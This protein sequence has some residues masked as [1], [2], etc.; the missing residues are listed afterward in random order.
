MKGM[1]RTISILVVDDKEDS[2]TELVSALQDAGYS[3]TAADGGATALSIL[4]A[5]RFDLLL[6]D[7]RVADITAPEIVQIVRLIHTPSEL[8]VIVLNDEA[9]DGDAHPAQQAVADECITRPTDSSLL[10]QRIRAL[11]PEKHTQEAT[12]CEDLADENLEALRQINVGLQAELEQRKRVEGVLRKEI[13]LRRHIERGLRADERRF[14]LL[15]DKTPTMFFTVDLKGEIISANQFGARNLGY[16]PDELIGMPISRLFET[17]HRNSAAQQLILCLQNPDR[18][19]RR[20]SCMVRKDGSTLWVRETSRAAEGQGDDAPR[21]LLIVCEDI[22]EAR[23]LSEQLSYQASHDDLTGLVNRWEF[24]NRLE[25]LISTAQ[26]TDAE[27]ALCYLDLDQFKVIN[28]TCGH[29]A[30]DEL[31]RQLAQLLQSQVQEQDTLARLGGDEFGVLIEHCSM[32]QATRLADTLL[33][34]FAEFRF[35]WQEKRFGIGGS[36]GV[37]PIT[38]DSGTLTDILSAADAA[39]YEAKDGGRN[40]VKQYRRDDTTMIRRNGVMR[41]M[42]Q[43][44]RAIEEE[45]FQLYYQPI[46]ALNEEEPPGFHYELLI[47]MRDE[48]G[49]FVRPGAFLPAAERFNMAQQLDRWTIAT[50]LHW[51]SRY[52]EHVNRLNICA[53]NLSGQ[54][55]SEEGIYEH[56]IT[57]FEQTGV[58]PEK[59]CFEVTETAAISNINRAT[60]L[61]ASLK[62]LG[63]TFALDDFGSGLSSFAYLK[64][65]PVDFLKIDGSFVKDIESDSVD[66]AMVKSINEIAQ[67]MGKKTIAEFVENQAILNILREIGVDYVQGYGIGQP[68]PIKGLLVDSDSFV[69]ER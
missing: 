14:R 46:E 15:Y 62:D 19:H 36:I 22:T 4:D 28:D 13:K 67:V 6:I 68:L 42:A 33:E 24:K 5:R 55:L 17:N 66:L 65:L 51:L 52:P 44:H 49:R 21:N 16:K 58:P 12:T 29:I 40:R 20:E 9:S 2:R 54:S 53:L 26:T 23:R 47:R 39:C 34:R 27:H 30:G 38:K 37:V 11:L 35:S 18:V 1:D 56:I 45:R 57:Q 59:I 7:E 25:H 64:T 41:V 63:C 48:Y 61:M 31:L 60:K 69:L 50:A 3:V 8:P 32:A 10:V 43:L